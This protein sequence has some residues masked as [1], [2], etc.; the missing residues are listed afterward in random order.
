M[1]KMMKLDHD[2]MYLVIILCIWLLF[3]DIY[4]L[5]FY[6]KQRN[7]E[8]NFISSVDVLV[9]LLYIGSAYLFH[10]LLR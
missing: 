6:F 7:Q 3:S 8:N 2:F 4:P 10:L 1:S 9:Y 5:N